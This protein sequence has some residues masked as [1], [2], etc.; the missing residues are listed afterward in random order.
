MARERDPV[1]VP[2]GAAEDT[3]AGQRGIADAAGTERST[4]AEVL[5]WAS[6]CLDAE[7]LAELREVLARE[8]H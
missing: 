8:R 5:A 4:D 6:E 7:S 2:Y 3:A 1:H